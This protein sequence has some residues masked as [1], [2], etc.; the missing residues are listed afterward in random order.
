MINQILDTFMQPIKSFLALGLLSQIFTVFA[1]LFLWNLRRKYKKAINVVFEEKLAQIKSLS[2]HIHNNYAVEAIPNSKQTDN[3]TIIQKAPETIIEERGLTDPGFSNI[4]GIFTGW[5]IFFTFFGIAIGLMFGVDFTDSS[6]LKSIQHLIGGMWVSFLSSILGLGFSIWFSRQLSNK[7]NELQQEAARQV[8]E[9]R[10]KVMVESPELYLRIQAENL[11]LQAKTNETMMKSAVLLAKSST[12]LSQL[13]DTEKMAELIGESLRKAFID[14]LKPTFDSI[15][16]K[17]GVLTEIQESTS[18]LTEISAQLR[19]FI[20]KDLERIFKNIHDSFVTTRET[21][22]KVNNG[23]LGTQD[24][25]KETRISIQESN[26]NIVMVNEGLADF[27]V[28][29][30]KVLELHKTETINLLKMTGDEVRT[31]ISSSNDKLQTTLSGVGD[32]LIATSDRIQDELSKFREGYTN[33]L[34]EYL[35]KQGEVLENVIGNHIEGLN[36][37]TTRLGTML[38]EEYKRREKMTNDLGSMLERL[39]RVSAD[40][41]VIEMAI[42]EELREL[43]SET[44]KKQ[45]IVIKELKSFQ[46]TVTNNTSQFLTKM[47]SEIADIFDYFGNVVQTLSET[48]STINLKRQ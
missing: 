12:N 15:D 13:L 16:K 41:K 34:D 27:V 3:K 10:K 37:T 19:T 38:E 36:S 42:K 33:S 21:V 31:V 24:T 29:M 43:S 14:E 2:E 48:A 20:V 44:F 8:D 40:Q 18:Q 22:E 25:I 47:D 5:G 23:L 7:E 45:D 17:F 39:S 28:R 30:Q 32:E 1:I 11:D 46:H 35:E 26:K 6:M 4:P 9:L